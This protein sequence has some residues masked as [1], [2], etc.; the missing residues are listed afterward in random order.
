[1]T[2][3]K[4]VIVIGAGP[5]GLSA[6]YELAKSGLRVAVLETSRFVGGMARSF[7]LWGHRVDLGPHRFLSEERRVNELWIELLGS[8]FS[9]VPR[10]TRILFEGK[11]FSYPLEALDLLRQLGIGRGYRSFLSFARQ[12][13]SGTSDVGDLEQWLIGHFGEYLYNI[14]FRP[15][16]EKLWGVPCREIDPDFAGQRIRKLDLFEVVRSMMPLAAVRH[17]TLATVFG[18]P[19]GGAGALYERMA[20]RIR[21]WH[22]EVLFEKQV[23]ALEVSDGRV[24]RIVLENGETYR[25]EYVVSSMPLTH[26]LRGISTTPDVLL[27]PLNRLRFRTTHLVYLRVAGKDL[28]PDQW[29]YVQSPEMRIGRITN[30][31]NWGGENRAVPDTVL[32][33]ELWSSPGEIL[34]GATD[35]RLIEQTSQELESSGLLGGAP[36]LERKVIRVPKCYPILYRGYKNDLAPIRTFLN[37]IPNLLVI[38]RYG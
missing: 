24:Q 9:L 20:D 23:K 16:S 8:N 29:I 4:D 37:R 10:H 19:H 13:L 33:A 6:A 35:A 2:H 21:M 36:I 30:Y 32:S 28:F 27:A 38:G 22:G 5:A 26:L 31:D 34:H 11:C 1:M 18:Y 25:S 17:R 15:Y 7:D 3:K 14:F 12:K